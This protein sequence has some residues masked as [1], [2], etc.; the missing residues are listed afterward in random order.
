MVISLFLSLSLPASF[1]LVR[2]VKLHRNT[3]P[4]GERGE[5]R[6]A[7]E[8]GWNEERAIDL[9]EREG[10]EREGGPMTTK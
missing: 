3:T 1:P 8:R 10:R 2:G 6:R 7:D 4:K 9:R 5:E